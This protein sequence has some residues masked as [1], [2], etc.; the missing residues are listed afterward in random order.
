ML[1]VLALGAVAFGVY[2]ATFVFYLQNRSLAELLD[3]HLA[4]YNFH[5]DGQSKI[6][7]ESSGIIVSQ[8]GYLYSPS[9]WIFNYVTGLLG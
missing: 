6:I 7:E 5:S 3:L 1:R 4:M 9:T 8:L 2:I